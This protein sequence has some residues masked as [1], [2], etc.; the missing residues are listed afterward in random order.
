VNNDTVF[1][2]PIT[3]F[4]PNGYY[5]TTING[6][7]SL[8]NKIYF[9]L[10]GNGQFR[11]EGEL[12][13]RES[14]MMD[15]N[16]APLESVPVRDTFWA[17]YSKP[18]DTNT[19]LFIWNN[20]YISKT[21]W[22][23]GPNVNSKVW[24]HAETLFVLPDERISLQYGDR[25]G[26]NIQVRTA[27]GLKSSSRTFECS[28]EKLNFSLKTSNT[29]DSMGRMRENFGLMEPVIFTVN[30]P[31]KN[32]ARVVSM[33]NTLPPGIM[34]SCFTIKQDTVIFT[35]QSI[36]KS[37]VIYGF[38]LDVV[39]SNGIKAFAVCPLQWKAVEGARIV[40]L[41]NKMP[42]GTYRVFTL[43]NDSLRVTFSLPIDTSA[44]S[45]LRFRANIRD[46]GN[47]FYR[48]TVTWDST[49]TKATIHL[50]DTLRS[51]DAFAEQGYTE[52]SP[53]T[54]AI[55]EVTFDCSTPD[56]IVTSGLGLL[57]GNIELHS[58][59]GLCVI[60]SNILNNHSPLTEVLAG[61]LPV[62]EFN[63]DSA[64]TVTFNRVL[65]TTAIVLEA[66]NNRVVIA[67]EGG[68]YYPCAL[69][70]SPDSR[71]IKIY[72]RIK[73]QAGKKY[74]LR[75]TQ[76]P[77][78]GIKN[79][80][81]IS[82]H[83]GAYTGRAA[84]N[85]L[86]EKP[87]VIKNTNITGVKATLLPDSNT[88][89]PAPA[90]RYGYS[91][92]D[93][94]GAVYSRIVGGENAGSNTKIILRFKE[95]AWNSFHDDSVGGYQIQAQKIDR[96]GKATAWYTAEATLPSA[97]FSPIK[98]GISIVTFSMGSEL[99]FP[100]FNT[101]DLDGDGVYYQN[102]MSIFND[103]ARIL[104]KIRPFVGDLNYRTPVV[105]AW[106]NSISIVDN[107]APCDGEFVC[108]YFCDSISYGGVTVNPTVNWKNTSSSLQIGGYVEIL[109]PEDMDI[110]GKSPVVSIYYG[111]FSGAIPQYPITINTALSRWISARNYRC[112]IN[113]PP[114][115]Y[116]HNADSTG[117]Y[118]N[119]NVAG[120]RD[121]AGN[122]I[123]NYG[124]DGEK[125]KLNVDWKNADDQI[126]GS[127]SVIRR[128][129]LCQ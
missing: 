54:R 7:D 45:L 26:F 66:E 100:A 116:T 38:A 127:A 117:S 115:D 91:A 71:T 62:T 93:S 2:D 126:Q 70:F 122:A 129:F 41:D 35:P 33:G 58:E 94:A 106:S 79:A 47:K 40:S 19:G 121:I 31:I 51:A 61:E 24:A 13:C 60:Q 123:Q 32:I 23:S 90:K 15:G 68:V 86:L 1:A 81:A 69:S 8:D 96:S 99:F 16:G 37:A 5:Y 44:R 46:A 87:F 10:S 101:Q 84:S 18:L 57:Q 25:V 119:V 52:F 103:S 4:Q 56:G 59:P 63:P 72:P 107:V 42:T 67:D 39:L 88:F 55:P 125:A 109:F 118:F 80:L 105:G 83:A 21:L 104:I 48:S 22:G 92:G 50:V 27:Q 34:P 78:A 95:A 82:K 102:K 120:C 11:T 112:A 110:R 20:P 64:L 12:V 76:I 113:I 98:D 89:L 14:N 128:F 108:G 73:M 6:T 97:S 9:Y 49:L 28:L 29:V 3:N 77:A 17:R 124:T 53:G 85:A 75:L 30:T 114:G 65:D 43:L 36:M 111:S 74:F